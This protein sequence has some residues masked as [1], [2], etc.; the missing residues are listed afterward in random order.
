MGT[1]TGF[2]SSSFGGDYISSGSVFFVKKLVQMLMNIHRQ[3]HLYVVHPSVKLPAA[4]CMSPR[5]GG[6][7]AGPALPQDPAQV[8]TVSLG[9]TSNQQS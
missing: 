9:Q 3:S 2:I 5:R 7:R 1:L 4:E 6:A 8:P